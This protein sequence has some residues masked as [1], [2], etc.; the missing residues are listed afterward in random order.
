MRKKTTKL[1]LIRHGQSIGN[2]TKRF[3]GHTDLDLSELGY[4]QANCTA[5]YLKNEKIDII[6]SSDLI[7]AYNTAVPH[8]KIRGLDINTSIHLRENFVG[9]WENMFVDDIIE[10]WG[11]EFF[12]NKENE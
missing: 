2:L 1:I 7:R 5:E 6:Y 9:E 8:A 4:L 11:R 10:K 3:L 12:V